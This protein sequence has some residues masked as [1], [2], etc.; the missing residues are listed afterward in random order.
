MVEKKTVSF[1]FLQI[2]SLLLAIR[3]IFWNL[4]NIEEVWNSMQL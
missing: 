3:Y 4:K 1:F 2:L